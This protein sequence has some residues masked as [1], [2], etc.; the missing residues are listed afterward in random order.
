M[1]GYGGPTGVRWPHLV[2][3]SS[4]RQ[5][6]C[7]L[8]LQF[9]K[10]ACCNA[11]VCVLEYRLAAV[12]LPAYDT[13]HFGGG[14]YNRSQSFQIPRLIR[15]HQAIASLI[16][17]FTSPLAILNDLQSH[18]PTIKVASNK[19]HPNKGTRPGSPRHQD[20]RSATTDR[21]SRHRGAQKQRQLNK[22]IRQIRFYL[23]EYE[24]AGWSCRCEWID[25]THRHPE[26]RCSH[27]PLRRL[28]ELLNAQQ[29]NNGSAL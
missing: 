7:Q 6:A 17:N 8:I 19:D 16:K 20:R 29:P 25:E 18:E 5:V 26:S 28:S 14:G 2:V 24:K 3:S 13:Q 9:G 11:R 22:E 15:V 27:C 12:G 1:V 10:L 21:T 4:T 23:R